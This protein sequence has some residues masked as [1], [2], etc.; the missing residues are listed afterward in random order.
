MLYCPKCKD[1]FREGFD[2]CN[3]CGSKLVTK[4]EFEKVKDKKEET[5]LDVKLDSK[6]MRVLT[7]VHNEE[8]A[9]VITNVLG[10]SGVV[11]AVRKAGKDFEILVLKAQEPI[12]RAVF[13]QYIAA[14]GG[15]V[16]EEGLEE[17]DEAA[18]AIRLLNEP[19]EVEEIKEEKHS[20]F[21]NVF[22]II[23]ILAIFAP[24]LFAIV[25]IVQKFMSM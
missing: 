12:A 19:E 20:H 11:P 13:A 25:K 6:D 2:T 8:E 15:G 9:K 22:S 24:I 4:E 17:L 18:E 5:K 23:A 1:E 16:T 10:R 3:V 14:S 21:D 7:T